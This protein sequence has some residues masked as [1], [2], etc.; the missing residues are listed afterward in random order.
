M[1]Q[2]RSGQPVKQGPLEFK[3]HVQ[4]FAMRDQTIL[5]GSFDGT[6]RIGDGDTDAIS[7][8][9]PNGLNTAVTALCLS[10]SKTTVVAASGQLPW[11]N[12]TAGN[13]VGCV[14]YNNFLLF[15]F[16]CC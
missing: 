9:L 5:V 14:L 8:P 6:V 10:K 2:W 3:I 1:R 4:I 12:P 13:E 16:C 15:F 7:E 11:I